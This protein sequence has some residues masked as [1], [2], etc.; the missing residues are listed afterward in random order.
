MTIDEK[1][2]EIFKDE[3]SP[4]KI[5]LMAELKSLVSEREAVFKKMEDDNKA[6][7]EAYKNS[8]MGVKDTSKKEEM[9]KAPEVKK[10]NF[11][12]AFEKE[13]AK[14]LGEQK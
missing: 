13:V 8:L 4:E 9:N 2:N 5:K 7:A 14:M 11:D 10:F 12:E 6:L 1:I 3:S